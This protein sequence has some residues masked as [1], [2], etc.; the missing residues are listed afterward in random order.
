[1]QPGS[2]IVHI[3]SVFGL[4][5]GDLPVAAYNTSKAGLIGCTGDLGQLW[6]S[7]KGIR[8]NTL[9]PGFFIPK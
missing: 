6:G 7:R 5:T 9:A 3:A 2:S 4:T 8:V 1:M